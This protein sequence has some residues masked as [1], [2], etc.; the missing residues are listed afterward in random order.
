MDLL[1]GYDVLVV[2]DNR[3]NCELA[4]AALRDAVLDVRYCTDPEEGLE[5]WARWRPRVVLLDYEM[6][7]M[8]GIFCAK[9]IR[10]LEGEAGI[11]TIMLMV[12]AHAT[13]EVVQQAVEAGFNGFIPKPLKAADV[14]LRVKYAVEHE[15]DSGV[16][17]DPRKKKASPAR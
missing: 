15:W 14:L 12:T 6:P 5:T 9:V 2:D 13:P 1:F 10:Q 4:S 16:A 17:P 7:K 3:A 11:R 8:N